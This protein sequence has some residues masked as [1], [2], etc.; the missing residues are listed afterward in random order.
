MFLCVDIEIMKRSELKLMLKIFIFFFLLNFISLHPLPGFAATIVLKDGRKIEVA[1]FWEEGDFLKYQK[2]GT[3]IGLPLERIKHIKND[4]TPEDSCLVDFGFDLWKMGTRLEDVI[5][6]AER[7][8]I[9]LSRAGFIP[10]T[11]HFSAKLCRP[12]IHTHSKFEYR[13]IILGYPSKVVLTFTPE[14][15]RLALINV[16]FNI[17][18]YEPGR[19]PNNV[20]GSSPFLTYIMGISEEIRGI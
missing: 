6:I 1:R 16:T 20:K 13:Q 17:N 9:P 12:Y 15:K 5:G 14:S 4:G 11:K 19:K 8:D 2:Y 7:N 18:A 3:T 10:A